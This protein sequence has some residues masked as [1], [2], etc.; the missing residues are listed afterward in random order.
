MTS[1]SKLKKGRIKLKKGRIKQFKKLKES[2]YIYLQHTEQPHDSALDLSGILLCTFYFV[3]T[4]FLSFLKILLS[5][6]LRDF[7]EP[8]SLLPNWNFMNS[9]L[10]FTWCQKI[11]THNVISQTHYYFVPLKVLTITGWLCGCV[12]LWPCQLF[13]NLAY[14]TVNLN[15]LLHPHPS[16]PKGSILTLLSPELIALPCSVHD[17]WIVCCVSTGSTHN[18]HEFMQSVYESLEYKLYI[19]CFGGESQSS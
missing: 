3:G 9:S 17:N 11:Q 8:L 10:V 19:H 6:N 15:I 13:L 4:F 16:I 18:G 12:A 5:S 1:G 2:I 14:V 7:S